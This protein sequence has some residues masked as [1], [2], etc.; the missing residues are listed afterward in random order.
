MTTTMTAD[1]K[2]TLSS[3]IRGLRSRLLDD[4]HAATETTYRLSVRAQDA[5]LT[6]AARTRRTRLDAWINEQLRAQGTS[7]QQ[8]RASNGSQRSDADFRREAEEQAAYTLLN[9]LVI[10]RL[11]ET[12]AA[13]QQSGNPLRS[14]AMVTGGWESRA[15][16]DF[17]QLAPALVR[18]DPTEGYA[19]LLQLIFEDLAVDLPGL[20][21][22]VGIADLIPIPPATLRH[23]IEEL[24]KPELASC[25]TDDMTLGWIYQYW[26]DPAREALDAKLNAGSKVEPHE[27]AS[28]TQMFTERYMV[29]W[30]LQNSLGPMWLAICK[31]QGWT[32]QVEADGTLAA[33]EER[34]IDWRAKRDAGEVALTDLMPLQTDAE[35]RWAYYVP[36]PIPEDAVTHAPESLRDIKLLDPAVGSGHFLVVALTLLVALYKEEA[37]H[38]GETGQPHWSDRAIVERILAHNLHGI[39]LDPR[40]VQIAAAALWIKG[41]QIAP[42]A[43]PEQINLVASNLRLASL[44]DDDPALVEL[45]REVERETGIPA[46]LTDTVIQALAGADHLGSLLKVN[47]AV[48]QALKQFE[49]ELGTLEAS[50]GD[51]F[52]GFPAARRAPMDRAQA[53]NT[54]LDRLE[55]FLSRHSRGDDLGLRLRGEQLAAG[56]RFV[57]MVQEGAY[58]LVVANPPYQGA[59]DLA[60]SSYLKR[61]YPLGKADLYAAFLLRG[62]ELVSDG[63]VSSMLTM[64]NWMFVK[65]YSELRQHLLDKHDLRALGDFEIGAFEE[66]GGMVVSVCISVLRR[67]LP[68]G[69]NSI[70]QKLTLDETEGNTDRTQHKRAATLCHVGR[71]EFDPAAL[72]VVPEWPLVYSWG[73]EFLKQYEMMPKLDDVAPVRAG[74]QTSGNERYLRKAWEVITRLQR[75]FGVEPPATQRWVPY[76]KGADGAVWFEPLEYLIKWIKLG[77]E[78][79]VMYDAFGSKG[80]GNGMPSKHL[81]FQKGIAFSMIGNSFLARAHRFPS[82]MG[83]KGSSVFPQSQELFESTL[84]LMNSE[85]SRFIMKSL[86]PGVGFEVGDVKRLPILKF[87]ESDLVLRTLEDAFVKHVKTVENDVDFIYP[88]FSSWRYAQEWA[89][90]AVDRSEGAALPDYI[91]ELD[92]EPSTDHLSFALGVA[93]GRF[94]PTCEGILDP[95][96]DDLTHA[97]PGGILFLD[98]TLDG[99]DWRDSLGHPAATALHQAWQTY[100]PAIGTKRKSLRQWLALDFFKDVHKGMYENRPIHWP[101]S[102]TKKTFVAWVTIHR[103][104]EQTLTLLL[105]DQL[106][107]ALNRLEGEL[108]DLR[109]A[110]D[111][112]DKKAASAAEKRY[113]QVLKARDEL[114]D[115]IDA[116]VQCSNRGAPPTD[117]STSA[118]CPPREQDARYAP[119]LDDG[120]MI[121]SAALWPLLDPLWKDPKKW[122]KELSTAKGRKDYDWSHLAMRYWP[123]RVDAKCQEDPSLGVAHGCF[124]HYHP[125]RAWAWELRLQDEIGPDFRIEEA[126]YHP[127]G[128]SVGMLKEE[129]E[130]AAEQ[131]DE[132]GDTLHRDAYLRDH[133]IEAL[134]AV[135]KEAE[136]RMGR[137]KARTAIASMTLLEA[138]LWSAIPEYVWELELTLSEKQGLEFRLHAPDE[139]AAR[140]AYEAANPQMVAARK[141]LLENLVAVVG[142]FDQA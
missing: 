110:R 45:R 104:N 77:L 122:W 66:V 7:A 55:T 33:L 74:M 115:F 116:V 22:P 59:G 35:R 85:R 114:S 54:L 105:A 107:P 80:G 60:D 36:Q 72:K 41:K 27:I 43:Q 8:N 96:K 132:Q 79:R 64:R 48:E 109:A 103:F 65:Q 6:Q 93:L 75:D 100:G 81:Y 30:L 56:V 23:V 133:P 17:R 21:G 49:G 70:A 42:D 134:K 95:T 2:R 13:D 14:P 47:Q 44:P 46:Q 127:A 125:A 76:I 140:A 118:S 57:R 130:K 97:L 89:Q 67:R 124:W 9:R 15:Y 50:Q 136:R 129:L 73:E 34:R 31:K 1:A 137:G 106:Q 18:E 51:L 139:A 84:C 102:S 24:D 142:L 68:I 62:L 53:Q 112:V 123:T 19:F 20:Y 69:T 39:D 121:N 71:H 38:R 138:G 131:S 32:P 63:G 4:L 91:E 83:N 94:S 126:P 99:E 10:L 108:T 128:L 120:V 117:N 88:G 82:I 119:D 98:G 11:M 101:L 111:G 92:P 61:Q 58:D 87:S 25:W 29:D 113:D 37:H 28:K 90:T 52:D 26:N 5:G 78:K 12:P 40:A 86:N 135:A 141:E 3:T 16:M